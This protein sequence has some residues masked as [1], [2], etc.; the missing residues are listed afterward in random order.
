MDKLTRAEKSQQTKERI[1]DVSRRI[2]RKEGFGALTVA[3]ICQE[4]NVVNGTFYHFFP[5]KQAVIAAV[6]PLESNLLTEATDQTFIIP[7]DVIR[8]YVDCYADYYAKIGAESYY[9][10]L[11]PSASD[12]IGNKT[13]YMENRPIFQY[14][15]THL[16]YFKEQGAILPNTDI[17]QLCRDLII[18]EIGLLYWACST[19][20]SRDALADRAYSVLSQVLEGHLSH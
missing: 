19:G 15:S 8:K 13:M 4:A 16:G 20:Q 7:Q 3:R 12:S 14:L 9:R 17:P 1:I 18:C 11:F 2:L 5:T 6:F 10:I